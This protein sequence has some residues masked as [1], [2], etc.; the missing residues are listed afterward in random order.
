MTTPTDMDLIRK[1][2]QNHGRGVIADAELAAAVFP[3]LTESNLREYLIIVS[4]GVAE[5]LMREAQSAPRTEPAWEALVRIPGAPSDGRDT[6]SA[7]RAEAD[8][9]TR[10]RRGV[11]VLRGHIERKQAAASAPGDA[12]ASETRD[13]DKPAADAPE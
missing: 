8:F 7:R 5:Q 6:P 10:Y 4:R 13:A 9:R 2:L 12:P 11:E 3:S 1:A